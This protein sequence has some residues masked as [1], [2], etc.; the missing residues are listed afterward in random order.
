MP[1]SPTNMEAHRAMMIHDG[2]L[3][4]RKP[5]YLAIIAECCRLYDEMLKD[6]RK[7]HFNIPSKKE[8]A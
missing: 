6:R 2:R 4:N 3:A 1:K 5:E 8:A 7:P